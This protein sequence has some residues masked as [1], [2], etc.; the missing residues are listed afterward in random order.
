MQKTKIEL[1][2]DNFQNRKVY[3][4]PK[5]QLVIADIPYNL[6]MNAYAS[7]PR[8]YI[9]G[10]NKN[11]ESEFAGK[12]FFNTD[13][14]FNLAEYM[15]FCSRLLKPEPKEKNQAP[16]MIVFCAFEQMH[17]IISQGAKHGFPKSYPIFFIKN[18]STQTLKANMRIVGAMEY[19]VV[20]YRDKLPKFRT[21]RKLDGTGNMIFNWFVWEK[22]T[23]E[24]GIP[25]IHPTQKPVRMLK[26][27]IRIFTDEGDTVIDPVA[28]SGTTLRA[29]MEL[30][31]NCYGFEIDKNFYR[32]AKDKMLIR[33]YVEIE[34]DEKQMNLFNFSPSKLR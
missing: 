11:G 13:K 26:R 2:N 17:T 3:N 31:R 4:I 12:Q 18:Y 27:L 14:N 24:D 22:D 16:A 10:D 28:G 34:K 7:S 25:K 29:C 32:E 33:N 5:A 23:K 30:N 20:L 15:H 6:G 8:W 9:G 19:A 1:Y 21:I